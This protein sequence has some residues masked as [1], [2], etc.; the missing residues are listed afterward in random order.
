MVADKVQDRLQAE[1]EA[2][3]LEMKSLDA[4]LAD[5]VARF[6]AAVEQA[7]AGL[8]ASVDEL[9]TE[10]GPRRGGRRRRRQ[11]RPPARRRAHRKP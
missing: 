2:A 1:I 6:A 4:R 3:L 8:R 9:R 10:F 5:P 11:G 7:I